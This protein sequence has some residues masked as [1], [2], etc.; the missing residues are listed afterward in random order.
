[1]NEIIACYILCQI[2]MLGVV[3]LFSPM[4][5]MLSDIL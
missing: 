4:V 1:M 2:F 5:A 3:I